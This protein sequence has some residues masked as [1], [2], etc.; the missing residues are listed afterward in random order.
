MD[1]AVIKRK[2]VKWFPGENVRIRSASPRRREQKRVAKGT[3]RYFCSL[4][5]LKIGEK[6]RL[7]MQAH[8]CDVLPLLFAAISGYSSSH[9]FSPIVRCRGKTRDSIMPGAITVLHISDMQFGK[10]HR[11]AEKH[12]NPPN[13]RDKLIT[14]LTDDL[15]R[16]AEVNGLRPDLIICTGDLAEWGMPREFADAFDFLGKLCLYCGV[17]RKRCI[18]IP[19]NHDINRSNCEAYFKECQGDGEDPKFPWFPKWK[20]FKSA[21]DKFYAGMPDIA[22]TESTPWSLFVD[23]DL[24]VVVAGLNSTMA[25]GHDEAVNAAEREDKGHHGLCTEPQLAWFKERLSERRFEG[26]LRIGAVHHNV[27]RGCRS[28]NENLRDAELIGSMLE[29]RLHLLLHG[30]THEAKAG[31][32][33]DRMRVYSTGSASL[34]TGGENPQVPTDVPNQYQFL[35]IER[36]GVTRYCR[37]YAPR[38]APPEF[39]ADVRQSST[40]CDWIVKDNVDFS[41]VVGFV[42]GP[43]TE[44]HRRKRSHRRGPVQGRRLGDH[45]GPP[46]VSAIPKPP[47]FYAEPDYIGSHRFVGREQQILE[48]NDWAKRADQTSLLLFEAIGG[49]GKSMLTWE[50]ATNHAPR[51]RDD[52]SGRFW[53]SFYEKGAIMAD[54]CRRALAYMT[55][56]P[57]EELEKVPMFDLA[58]ELLAQLH[59]KPWLLILDGLERVLVAYHRVDAA[60][61]PDEEANAPTDKVLD[62]NPCDTIRDEDGDLLRKLAACTPSKILVSSRLTPRV[63]L[64]HSGQPIA[65]A[66]RITLPGLR[67][68]DAEKLLRSCD[69]TGD[70]ARIQDYLTQNC[71]NHP[72]V[73]GVLAGLIN[74]PGSARGNFDAWLS[75]PGP[76]GGAKLDLGN[77]DLIQ[78]RNHILRAALGALTEESRQLLST[79]ALL[80]ESVDYETL[81]AFNPHLP[82]DEERLRDT[83][84]DLEQRS[85]LQYDGQTRRHD[86]H[87]V[88]RGVAVGGMPVADR[89]RYGQRVVDHFS[90]QPHN[91]YE[92]A[93]TLQDVVSGLHV[94][95]TLLKLERYQEAANAYCGPLSDALLF[96]LEA[97]VEIISLLKPF[98]SSGWD[99]LPK[100]IDESNASMLAYNA[101]TALRNCGELETA[102]A[103]YGA[104]LHSNLKSENWAA[105]NATLLDISRSLEVQNQL[106]DALRIDALALEL[107]SVGVTEELLFMSRLFLFCD[108]S[109]IGQNE[110]AAETW[111]LLDSMGRDWSRMAYRQGDAERYFARAQFWQG[112]LQ[113]RHLENATNIALKGNN[114]PALRDLHWLRGAWRLEQREWMLATE[115]FQVAVRMARERRLTDEESEAG[116]AL[117][118][119]HAGQFVRLTEGRQEIERLAAQRRPAHRYIAK[120]WQALEEHE[121]AKLHAIAAYKRAWADGEPYVNRYELTKAIELLHGMRIPIPNLPPYDIIQAPRL[122]WEARIS[123]EIR[124]I[125]LLETGSTI[126]HRFANQ[127]VDYLDNTSSDGALPALPRG[128]PVLR[129]KSCR[130]RDIMLFSDSG[131]IDLDSRGVLLLGNNAAGKSTLLKCIALASVGIE[132]ANEVLDGAAPDFLRTGSEWGAIEVCFELIPAANCTVSNS[133]CFVV[134][135]RIDR[136]SDRFTALP[137]NELTIPINRHAINCIQKLSELRRER[138]F[139]FGFICAYGPGRSFNGNRDAIEPEH[140]L[141]EKEWVISLFDAQARLT[142]PESLRRL[143][144]GDTRN[145]PSVPDALSE[146]LVNAIGKGVHKLLPETQVITSG[147]KFD[148]K[149]FGTEVKLLNLSDGYRCMLTLVGHLIRC[150]LRHMEWTQNPFSIHGVLMIDEL[151]AHLHP[152]WQT[153]VFQDLTSVFP[154]LQIIATTHSPLVVAGA[155]R[156]RILL[157][158]KDENGLVIVDQP[159]VEPEG[160]GVSGILKEIFNLGST[161]DQPTLDKI[162]RRIQLYASREG[163]TEDEAA[164]YASLDR[165]LARLGFKHEFSDPY[166]ESFAVAM[167]RDH[168]AKQARVTPEARREFNDYVAELLESIK[169]RETNDFC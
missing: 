124:N 118:K 117:A 112:S 84:R 136:N 61:V 149:I 137:D 39:I 148:I 146:S 141:L 33:S 53:Y 142:S 147:Q 57:M 76:E 114:R 167:A 113:E 83:V 3:H 162:T 59:D 27:I 109:R 67:P 88:V 128:F 73:I 55:R 35:F 166:F 133:P 111:R 18:V 56:R 131:I 48:L 66:K 80:S 81:A 151:D 106:A 4:A 5:P 7:K 75:D 163:W 58:Q 104:V 102:Q 135:L 12:G 86:L 79:L 103:A 32:L 110:L 46:S 29:D 144:R 44:I 125:R 17:P 154:N 72:L 2:N 122:P 8:E 23:G 41:D 95:R 92:Q 49:N 43:G 129:V 74:S 68:A 90:S 65:G 9:F 158:D 22:F 37:Q 108:Q 28:D 63:L 97:H 98:F 150:A 50:W 161:I 25:E 40:K 159:E 134:G 70:S 168:A 130:L 116:L 6:C 24:E 138:E 100:N 99:E 45:A 34:R 157:L 78:R 160:L 11:F 91:P 164:E 169:Q 1:T 119:L 145:I 77:L 69:I 156:D 14:R 82:P 143:L 152:L 51:I 21:F 31:V 121:S 165:Y 15:D 115:S 42:G 94:V 153:H 105:A 127:W 85:L 36:G 26:W 126:E 10:F 89:D 96:N 60:E 64:N 120:L 132:V 93:K 123:S 19:G 87:P 101:A 140:P 71:D 54:F 62:R 13:P 52:W 139:S 38:N 16:L 30:H 47:T 20:H 155:K 107:A